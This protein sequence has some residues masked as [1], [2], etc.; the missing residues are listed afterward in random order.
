MFDVNKNSTIKHRVQLFGYCFENS[1]NSFISLQGGLFWT[2]DGYKV[3]IGFTDTD[4]IVL[5]YVINP[6][7][8][9]LGYL[10][11]KYNIHKELFNALFV[12]ACTQSYWGDEEIT[13]LRSKPML[14]GLKSHDEFYRYFADIAQN[15][16]CNEIYNFIKDLADRTK[17]YN[18]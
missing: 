11:K 1:P 16:S 18:L 10:S 6:T 14:L 8:E 15:K 2:K 7:L 13:K 3:E 17:N 4:D 12:G 5:D 9:E